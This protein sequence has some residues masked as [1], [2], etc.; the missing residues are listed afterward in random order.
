LQEL[1]ATDHLQAARPQAVQEKHSTF[2]GFTGCKPPGNHASGN[3]N[4][5]S[6]SAQARRHYRRLCP[7]RSR[8]HLAGCHCQE[9]TERY[10]RETDEE[11]PACEHEAY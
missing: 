3:R 11:Q 7:R 9:S 5:Y 1:R 6:M 4:G 2:P 8:Q 10:D